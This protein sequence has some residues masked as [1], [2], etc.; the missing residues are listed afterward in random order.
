MPEAQYLSTSDAALM[1]G[2]SES[3]L[4]KLRSAGGGSTFLKIGRRCVYRRDQ[5]EAWLNAHQRPN[6]LEVTMD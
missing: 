1:S 6:T 2:L 4:S 3:Y 5:F